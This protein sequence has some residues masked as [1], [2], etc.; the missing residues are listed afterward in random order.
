MSAD[1]R[2]ADE[3]QIFE[4]HRVGIPPLGPYLRQVWDRREFAVELARANLRAQHYD[5]TFGQLWLILNPLLLVAVYFTLVGIIRGG[6][7]GPEFFAHLML[8]L[9]A[10]RLVSTSV[11]EGARS[12]INGKR[13]IYNVAFPRTLLP[14]ASVMTAFMRFLPTLL[15]YAVVHVIAGLPIG[16][17]LL[18]AVPLFGLFLLFATGAAMITAAAQVY[19]RDLANFLPYIT[20]IWLYVSPVLFY[21]DE[22]PERLKPILQVNPLYPLLAGL[23][24]TVNQGQN[25]SPGYLAAGAA[26]AFA[27]FIVGTLFFVSREREFAVRL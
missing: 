20:R 6:G 22:I 15:I 18:W 7:R 14:L 10:F 8:A 13:L 11:G 9:F 1:A 24:E 4:P 21:V 19:F 23:S 26:W 25:L 2:V 12:V 3:V 5:T 16:P 17:E 27:A